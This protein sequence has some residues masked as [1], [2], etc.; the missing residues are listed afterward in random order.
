MTSALIQIVSHVVQE[1]YVSEEAFYQEE[2]GLTHD[3][4]ESW[5]KGEYL[6]PYQQTNRIARLFTDYEWMLV[7]K[8]VRHADINVDASRDAV[9]EY[10]FLKYQIAKSWVNHGLAQLKWFQ[11]DS[12]D[13]DST[14]KSNMTILQLIADYHFWG[15]QDVLEVRLPGV[16]RQQLEKD[17]V[18]LLQYF[19]DEAE[20]LSK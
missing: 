19:D 3:Q 11:S 5:K 16:M 8:V 14:R 13:P 2:L 1:K 12:N 20:K 7:Q 4:W 15:Y 6:I 17:E 18:K 10:L 9:K